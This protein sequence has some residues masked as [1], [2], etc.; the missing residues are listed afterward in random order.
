MGTRPIRNTLAV[1]LYRRHCTGR[2]AGVTK[3]LDQHQRPSACISG[4][5]W[6]AFELNPWFDICRYS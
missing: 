4:L 3:A 1:A 5:P 6:I 2:N